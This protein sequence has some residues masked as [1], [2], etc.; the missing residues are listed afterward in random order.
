MTEIPLPSGAGQVAF[1]AADTREMGIRVKR[2][3]NRK[4]P[5]RKRNPF[6]KMSPSSRNWKARIN[7]LLKAFATPRYVIC[8]VGFVGDFWVCA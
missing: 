4:H 1:V 6:F 2:N 7:G 3:R 5:A 8:F